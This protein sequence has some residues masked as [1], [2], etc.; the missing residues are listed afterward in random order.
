MK[1]CQH[2]RAAVFLEAASPLLLSDEARHNLIFGICATLIETPDAYSAFHSWVIEDAGMIVAAAV[3]TPPFNLVVAKPQHPA[4]IEFLASELHRQEIPIPGVT[5]ALPEADAFADTWE[6]LAGAGG[7]TR[8]RQGIYQVRLPRLTRDVPGAMRA[9]TRQDRDLVVEWWRAFVAEALPPDAPHGDI[10]AN[11]DRR[12]TNTESR[13]A[14]WE[15]DRP[16]SVAGFG[17]RT[18][19]GMGIGPVYTPTEFR[20]RGYASALVANLSGHL[21]DTHGLDYCFLYTDLAN[22]TANRIYIDI[23]YELV[24]ESAQYAFGH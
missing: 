8:R 22:P 9:A 7:R 10:E 1:L 21:L 12:L 6:Q 16:V 13:I 14:L 5:G 11:V 4:A 24:A 18:P 20:R 2:D 3:M 19:H 17:G 23:G 15:H